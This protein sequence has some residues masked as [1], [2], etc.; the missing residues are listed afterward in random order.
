MMNKRTPETLVA[1]LRRR[2]LRITLYAIAAVALAILAVAH[3]YLA[4]KFGAM[5]II[6][7]E[8]EN[9]EA[10]ITILNIIGPLMAA[11]TSSCYALCLAFCIGLGF[12]IGALIGELTSYT[13]DQL[14]VEMWDRII[15]IQNKIDKQTE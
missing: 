3:G 8:T 12:A 14:L 10:E 2:K 11:C 7:P 6:N 4:Y 1:H 13:K 15:K 9:I 5:L